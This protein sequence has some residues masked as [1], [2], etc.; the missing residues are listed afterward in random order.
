[1]VTAVMTAMIAIWLTMLLSAMPAASR[2]APIWMTPRPS[3]VATPK[4]VPTRAMTSIRLPQPPADAVAEEGL[5]GPADGDGATA[6]V[7]RVGEGE[8]E[9]DV[10]GPGVQP[11]V[12]EGL[13]QGLLRELVLGARDARSWRGEVAEGLGDAVEDEADAHARGEE[14]SEPRA[15]REL[16]L[17]LV[18]AE[19]DAT[20]PAESEEQ[21]EAD[22]EGGDQ[23]VVPAEVA[24]DA[25]LQAEEQRLGRGGRDQRVGDEAEDDDGGRPEDPAA[26][27]RGGR[28]GLRQG[29]GM[30]GGGPGRGRSCRGHASMVPVEG[31]AVPITTSSGSPILVTIVPVA[32]SQDGRREGGGEHRRHEDGDLGVVVV[33]AAEPVAQ[34]GDEQG[35][36][37]AD[38]PEEGDAGEVHPFDAPVEFCPGDPGRDPGR[39]EDADGFTEDEG[40]D[41]ADRDGTGERRPQAVEATEGDAGGE[42]REHGDGETGGDG[43]EAVL[44]DLGEP[45][46]GV[47][48]ATGL[49]ADDGD[50]EAEEDAGDGRV[51]ARRVDESPHQ[52]GDRQQDEPVRSRVQA[53]EPPEPLR[54]EHVRRERHDREGQGEDLD[55]TGVDE[56]DD[57]DGDEVVHDREGE[58]E[59]PQRSSGGRADDG[60]DRDGERDV[61]RRGDRPPAHRLRVTEA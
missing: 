57:A 34:F 16:R 12:E 8:S 53:E 51:D 44:E 19:L 32:G 58:Q 48:P 24:D 9:D 36:G 5:E 23:D 2:P 40:G 4:S 37:E 61:G 60:E 18:L 42:E 43:P 27:L 59:D 56:R 50:G 15:G 26:Q 25:A 46:A 45:G 55:G 47:R 22:E 20:E 39:R 1:M 38:A 14:E 52:D 3:E 54:Q 10:D 21:A 41:D 28:D 35:H 7:D 49:A 6:P 29:S 30:V 17:V 31:P 13:G 11:P 33:S